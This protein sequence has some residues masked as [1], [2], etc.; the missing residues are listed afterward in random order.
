MKISDEPGVLREHRAYKRVGVNM[1]FA[2]R[3]NDNSYKMGKVCNLSRGGMFVDTMNHPDV[4]GY[5]I[6]SLDVEEFGKI[7]WVRG[8]VV[9]KTNTGM[10][11]SFARTDDKGLSNLLSY[12]SVPF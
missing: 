9:R 8:Y 3:D 1:K 2:Y 4:D 10:A 7:I 11:I 12:W 5:V 6:A